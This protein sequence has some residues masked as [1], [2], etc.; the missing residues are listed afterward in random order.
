MNPDHLKPILLNGAKLNVL[1][2]GYGKV[3][4]RKAKTYAAVGAHVTVV[5]PAAVSPTDMYLFYTMSF[6]AF[7]QSEADVFTQQHLVIA[8]TDDVGVNA[9]V[10]A[11]CQQS[12]KLLNRA[13]DHTAG[14]FFDMMYESASHY[15]VAISGNGESP[16]VAKF[17]LNQIKIQLNQSAILARVRLLA[18]KTPY[19]KARHIPYEHIEHIDQKTLERIEDE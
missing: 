1:I 11:H 7:M 10:Q 17:L 8:C 4:R 9:S 6:E 18:A 12:G 16:Y 5:D 19:L 14:H 3:G 13:D 2:V 15:T